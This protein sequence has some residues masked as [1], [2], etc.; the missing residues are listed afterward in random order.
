[1]L[2]QDP[3]TDRIKSLYYMYKVARGSLAVYIALCDIAHEKTKKR[4]AVSRSQIKDRTGLS[5]D[6][7]G[8][9][10]SELVFGGWITR[11]VKRKSFDGSIKTV[12]VVKLLRRMV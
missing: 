2:E 1:M 9:C 5:I 3:K 12:I 10:L 7:V 11:K 8:R 6:Y 4:F